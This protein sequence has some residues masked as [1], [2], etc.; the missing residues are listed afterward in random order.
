[1][2]IKDIKI[3]Q[4]LFG[5]FIIVIV[6]F[7][8]IIAYMISKTYQL[9]NLQD[10]SAKRSYNMLEIK[11]I[12][13]RLD[14]LYGIFADAV[15]NRHLD[16]SE[17][18][19]AIAKEQAL[20]DINRA[21]ELADTDQ[22]KVEARD[23]AKYVKEYLNEYDYIIRVLRQKGI[24]VSDEIS[25]VDGRID[26]IKG[27]AEEK[28]KAINDSMTKENKEADTYF[29][30]I[31]INTIQI[32]IIIVIF[33]VI[34]ALIAAIVITSGIKKPLQKIIEMLKF[35]GKGDFT[36]RNN[37]K[38]KDEIGKVAT[39]LNESS[40][41]LENMITNVINSVQSLGQA[42]EQIASGNQSLSQRTS[43]QA[44]SLEEIASTIEETTATI[45]QNAENAEN[46]NKMS[47]STS[48]IAEEG[49][50]VVNSAVSSI[51]D[52]SQ[53]SKKIGEIIT[54]INEISFQTN[55]LALNAA[56]EAAR[57]GEQGR[58]FAVVAGEVRNLA[59]RSATAAKQISILINDSVEKIGNGTKLVNKSGEAL[60]EIILAVKDAG[61]VISEIAAASVEQRL[62]VDQVN[63]AVTELDTMTQQ[64]AALVEETAAAGEEMSN[65][66]QEL[67]ELMG[68]F[69]VKNVNKF[70]IARKQI[71]LN[72]NEPHHITSIRK[73]KEST[74]G[75]K[76]SYD[77]SKQMKE[78]GFEEF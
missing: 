3:G 67:M 59:Q 30:T 14:K 29:D 58:G 7:G 45:K 34:V 46:A 75:Q 17:K 39:S 33:G 38:Q 54:M 26:Q 36:N 76:H 2:G 32:S 28:I 37:V 13:K 69:K 72:E 10:E 23:F 49:A 19:F 27:N 6:L 56:V 48:R 78:E 47:D 61:K 18:E 68:T 8:G 51:N 57:A 1:M 55:L 22:E 43:E 16:E 66:A 64:N 63:K 11:D 40:E 4:K 65:Q 25:L 12:E 9:S 41:M 60:K 35:F 62:G 52:I 44:S 70:G 21:Q 24:K 53:S 73:I 20:K 42:V 31:I 71:Y 15:I 74:A 5:S 50:I 77:I